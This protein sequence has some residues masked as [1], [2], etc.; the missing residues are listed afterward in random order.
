MASATLANPDRRDVRFEDYLG[1]GQHCRVF[2]GEHRGQ[3]VALK[4]RRTRQ[5]EFTTS[6]PEDGRYLDDDEAMAVERMLI[7]E[8]EI[9]SQIPK[10]PHIVGFG[11]LVADDNPVGPILILEL[12]SPQSAAY[13]F[14]GS[15]RAL[16]SWVSLGSLV[17][18]ASC[19][20]T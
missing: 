5:T 1:A 15:E 17:A 16:H 6:A 13:V 20:L 12:A 19:H 10:H 3:S 9:L 7:A 11:G 14:V 8:A 4:V 2:R 18:L